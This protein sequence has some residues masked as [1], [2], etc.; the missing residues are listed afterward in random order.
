[1]FQRILLCS[2]GSDRSITAAQAAAELTKLHQA[3]LTLLHVCQAP[4]IPSP[5]PGA[6]SL[7]GPVLNSYVLDMHHA[8]IQRTLPALEQRGVR[9]EILEE[10][11]NPAEIIARIANQ[12]EFDLIVLGSRGVSTDKAEK[13]S[14]VCHSMIHNAA[15]P[16]LVIR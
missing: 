13:L 14:S 8:V 7:S 12:Q 4:S 9:C 10:V 11:G 16:V 5:F 1:M 6:P 2:D 3:H 15:C